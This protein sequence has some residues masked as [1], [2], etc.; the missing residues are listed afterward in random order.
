MVED[1]DPH[2]RARAI[3]LVGGA[4]HRSPEALAAILGALDT[5]THPANR[6][7]LRWHVPGGV[8]YERTKPRPSRV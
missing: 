1:P 7:I 6:K 8:R 5:E 3:G 2:V 4:V